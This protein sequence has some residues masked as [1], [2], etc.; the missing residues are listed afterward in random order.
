[1]CWREFRGERDAGK[2]EQVIESQLQAAFDAADS[3]A[4]VDIAYEPV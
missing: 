1:M 3:W 4:G 2:T